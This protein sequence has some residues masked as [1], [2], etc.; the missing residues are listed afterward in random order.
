M[1]EHKR[2]SLRSFQL[3]SKSHK[4]LSEG[5][6]IFHSVSQTSCLIRSLQGAKTDFPQSHHLIRYKMFLVRAVRWPWPST[7]LPEA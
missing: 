3:V 1:T 7:I 5:A 2:T 4:P 6:D